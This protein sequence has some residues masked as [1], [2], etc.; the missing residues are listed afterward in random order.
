G[1]PEAV[2]RE[3]VAAHEPPQPPAG[4]QAGDTGRRDYA[5]GRRKREGVGRPVVLAPGEPRLSPHSS[6]PGIDVDALHPVQVDHYTTVGDRPPGD[7]VTTAADRDLQVQFARQ[8]DGVTYV[9]RVLA[10]GD[11]RRSTVDHAVVDP[12]QL[13]VG[14]VAGGDEL[15]RELLS[16]SP[17]GAE[18]NTPGPVRVCQRCSPPQACSRLE[19][20]LARTR[21]DRVS[22]NDFQSSA[23]RC[24]SSITTYKRLTGMPSMYSSNIFGCT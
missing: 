18:G 3:A 12:A 21:S 8:P 9:G 23:R 6:P 13:V 19:A 22:A 17:Q 1:R 7:V 11:Q 20:S 10:A 14:R 16:E 24:D 2:G 4:G 5:A 15:A